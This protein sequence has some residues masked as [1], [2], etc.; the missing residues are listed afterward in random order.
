MKPLVA[1]L[2]SLSLA[3]CF[4]NS[5]KHRTYAKLGEG[6]AM[7]AGIALLSTVKTGADCDEMRSVGDTSSSC[8]GNAEIVS[9]IGLG[10]ILAGL[11]GFIA[12]VSTSPDDKPEQPANTLTK[13]PIPNATDA[14]ETKSP[15]F[16]PA[17]RAAK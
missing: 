11:T 8:R 12:T 15:A 3:A 7:V 14:N 5:A 16:T 10:L 6:A 4:P 13:T 1:L 17:A 2:L 9:T